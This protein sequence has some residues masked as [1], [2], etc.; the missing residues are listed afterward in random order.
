MALALLT[1]AAGC[2]GSPTSTPPVSTSSSAPPDSGASSAPPA[3]LGSA[4]SSTTAAPAL[5]PAEE[6]DA[7]LATM[8]MDEKICQ[9]FM[10]L[11]YGSSATEANP[12]QREAN[13]AYLGAPTFAEAVARC[14]VGGV[15]YLARN[16]LDPARNTVETGNFGAP[17]RTAAVSASL[18]QVSVAGHQGLPL[19]IGADQ[20]EGLVTRVRE[21]LTT[22]AGNMSLGAAGRPEDAHAAAGV[23]GREIRTLGINTNFA[24]VADVNTNPANPVIGVRSF[25]SDPTAVAGLTGAAVRGSQE[26]GVAATAKHFPGHGDTAVDSHVGLPVINHDRATLDATDLVPFRAAIAAGT[27][28]IMPA[29]ASLPSIDPSGAPATLSH[30]LVTGLL[31]DEL[32]YDGVVLTDSLWMAGVRAQY[33]DDEVVV[34]ALVAGVDVLL[35]PPSLPSATAAIRAALADGVLTEARIDESVRRILLLKRKLGLVAGTAPVAPSIDGNVGTAEHRDLADRLALAGATLVTVNCDRFPVAGGRRAVVVGDEPAATTLAGELVAV[36]IPARRLGLNSPAERVRAEAGESGVVVVIS[37]DASPDR[38]ARMVAA[39]A[40]LA[41]PTYVVSTATPYDVGALAPVD[42]Y[43]AV[44]DPG[45][46]AL[47]AAA[48]V[49]SGRGTAGGRLPV[50]VPDRGG[51]AHALGS[52]AAPCP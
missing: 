43:L 47:R 44:Y 24:P 36:G 49:I 45:A 6:V 27:D 16:T 50:A 4:S 7:L 34:R 3:P 11:A 31:R 9:L 26:A 5:T 2:A 38:A 41:A 17:A 13:Q 42:A 30:P 14:P 23:V 52:A 33:G 20:E 46:T 37:G 10:V 39:L 35:S 40:D 1:L 12:A 51:G 32:G 22:F 25:G 48:R 28:L 21:P 15:A 18:Q 19:L 29:H 8:S